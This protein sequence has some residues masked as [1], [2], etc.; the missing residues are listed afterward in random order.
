[1][2]Q[3]RTSFL[4]PT[5]FL[6]LRKYLKIHFPREKDLFGQFKINLLV[7]MLVPILTS[8]GYL[9]FTRKSHFFSKESKF[10]TLSQK[11]ILKIGKSTIYFFV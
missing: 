11:I 4:N 2:L 9:K 10:Q 7:N 8:S 5:A 3:E 1:V 6:H